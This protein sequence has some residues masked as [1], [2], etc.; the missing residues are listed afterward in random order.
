[1]LAGKKLWGYTKDSIIGEV[2]ANTLNLEFIVPN[3]KMKQCLTVEKT[4][5]FKGVV[6]IAFLM[7]ADSLTAAEAI[8]VFT[9]EL[10]T[11]LRT[12]IR[13]DLPYR[14][15]ENR[16]PGIITENYSEVPIIPIIQ[17]TKTEAK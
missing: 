17:K 7:H 6:P 5:A 4:T 13:N 3:I 15:I 12:M 16:I 1:M 9:K 8:D 2:E 11:V 10:S 14:S